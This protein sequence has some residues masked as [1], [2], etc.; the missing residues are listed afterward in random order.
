M[1]LVIKLC[2]IL[3]FL[4]NLNYRCSDGVERQAEILRGVTIRNWPYADRLSGKYEGYVVDLMNEIADII[5]FEY[6][7][8]F[9][10]D[11]KYGVIQD[12]RINGMIGEVY[13]NRADFAIADITVTDPRKRFVDFTEPFMENDIAILVNKKNVGN[14]RSFKDLSDSD[15]AY[16]TYRSGSTH[17]LFSQSTDPVLHKVYSQMEKHPD[18]MASNAKEGVDKVNSTKYAFIVEGSFAEFLTG[19]YCDLTYI[20]D[21]KQYSP[22]QYAIAMQKDSPYTARFNSA[23]KKLKQNGRLAQIK[24]RYWKDRCEDESKTT[25]NNDNNRQLKNDNLVAQRPPKGPE[26]KLAD[27]SSYTVSG[28]VHRPVLITS[29]K[30]IVAFI[31][32]MAVIVY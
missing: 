25:N 11:G 5:G 19:L 3:I 26:I 8:Y 4:I 18:W 7:L 14:I 13:N 20:Q 23:I 32:L 17:H 28:T 9:S 24:A 1:N 15:L 30:V 16:G 22:R 10:P 12:N 6:R 27:S 2:L 31:L 29:A 21:K